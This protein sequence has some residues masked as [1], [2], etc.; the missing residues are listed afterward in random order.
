MWNDLR[1][2][3]NVLLDQW[4]DRNVR[5][6]PKGA[7]PGLIAVLAPVAAANRDH[8]A[9]GREPMPRRRLDLMSL[10]LG[11]KRQ[12]RRWPMPHEPDQPVKPRPRDAKHRHRDRRPALLARRRYVPLRRFERPRRRVRRLLSVKRRR[13]SNGKHRRAAAAPDRLRHLGKM[14]AAKTK[15]AATDV[16]RKTRPS[17]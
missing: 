8:R 16:A 14:R 12:G 17:G 5:A 10:A 1:G 9:N 11:V 13:T 2:P 6:A 4:N 7:R 15:T 3:W